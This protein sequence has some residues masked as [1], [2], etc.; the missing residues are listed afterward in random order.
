MLTHNLLKKKKYSHDIQTCL[1]IPVPLSMKELVRAPP[2]CLPTRGDLETIEI[3]EEFGKALLRPEDEIT[4]A[5]NL[6]AGF[7]DIVLLLER[8]LH[9]TNHKFDDTFEDFVGNCKT[10]WAVDELIRVAT[11]G[12]RSIHTVTVLD[13]FSF[14]PHQYATE[15]DEQCHKVLA[16]ILRAK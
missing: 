12:A 13:A 5:Q 11:K 1:D 6:S 15:Q 10:L 2:V 3:L 9:R 8:T 7:S 14:Q 4:Q 16:Q